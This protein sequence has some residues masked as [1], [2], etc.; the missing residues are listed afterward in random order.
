MSGSQ[1]GLCWSIDWAIPHSDSRAQAYRNV[2]G[3]CHA[4]KRVSIGN[5]LL[6]VQLKHIQIHFCCYCISEKRLIMNRNINPHHTLIPRLSQMSSVLR[7]I[8]SPNPDVVTIRFSRDVRCCLICK[9]NIT[10]VSAFP[11]QILLLRGVD[12][13][14]VLEA[15]RS[16][17]CRVT[18]AVLSEELDVQLCQE[19]TVPWQQLLL[20]W[21]DCVERLPWPIQCV[22]CFL[23]PTTSFQIRI[24]R[25][26]RISNTMP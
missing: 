21:Q 18:A 10:Q 17:S 9:L 2:V 24:S 19:V 25:F 15:V 26:L 11:P 23:W 22:V 13:V 20:P 14:S 5:I 4:G 7:V 16:A 6:K 12:Y 3:H 8:G 1:G